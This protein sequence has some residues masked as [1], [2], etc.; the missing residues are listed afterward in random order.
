MGM[1]KY[2][3][4]EEQSPSSSNKWAYAFA[5]I[6]IILIVNTGVFAVAFL[7]I[8]NQLETMDTSLTE[9]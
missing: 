4:P 6:L 8:Q 7:N 1:I 9:H 5:A 3:M 2:L